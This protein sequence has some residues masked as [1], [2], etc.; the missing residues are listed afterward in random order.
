MVESRHVTGL[1]LHNP[2]T[3]AIDL[4]SVLIYLEY[5]RKDVNKIQTYM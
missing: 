2:T 4:V 3:K 1:V 5:V